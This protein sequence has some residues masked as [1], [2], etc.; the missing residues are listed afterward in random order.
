M[1]LAATGITNKTLRGLMTGLLGRPYSINQAPYDLAR[2]RTNQLITRVPG[3][4][5]YILTRDGLLFA[6]LYTKIYDHVLGPLTTTDRPNAP[7]EFL[8]AIN[9]IDRIVADHITQARVP[10]AA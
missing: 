1:L 10:T 4:N 8:A 6:Y 9:T 2:L 7:P 5:C 3:R